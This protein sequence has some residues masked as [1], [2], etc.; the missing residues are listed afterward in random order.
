[1]STV[2]DRIK[3]LRL[4]LN[5]N[6]EDFASKVNISRN[7]VTLMESGK[8]NPSDRTLKDI[9]RIFNANFFWL[10]DGKGDMFIDFP[11][12]MIDE[13]V[14]HYDLSE[15]DRSIIEGFVKLDK[16][17]RDF[18]TSYLKKMFIE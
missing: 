5:I 18:F 15:L 9:S 8:R 4:T 1:M 10:R 14:N 6:Q 2:H 7:S 12:A 17:K 11:D 16:E 3:K 13:L